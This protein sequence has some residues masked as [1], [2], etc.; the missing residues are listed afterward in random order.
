MDDE[1][2]TDSVTK[3]L[4]KARKE[5]KLS[6]QKKKN[7]LGRN[8]KSKSSDSMKRLIPFR[9]SYILTCFYVFSLHILNNLILIIYIIIMFTGKF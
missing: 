3:R 5:R 4:K 9:V 1:S 7:L 2:D 8:V 6:I